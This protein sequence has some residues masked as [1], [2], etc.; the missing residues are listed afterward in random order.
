MR[1]C[2]GVHVLSLKGCQTQSAAFDPCVFGVWDVAQSM[3]S[4]L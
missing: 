2:K 3:G 1:A 4:G